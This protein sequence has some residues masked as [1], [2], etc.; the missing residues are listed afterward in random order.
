MSAAAPPLP[1]A[2]R[3]HRLRRVDWRFLLPS[4]LP[5]RTLCLAT[6][7]LAEG[8]ALVS[9]EVVSAAAPGTCDLALAQD[10][11]DRTLETLHAALRPGGACYTEWR[12]PRMRGV[13]RA[14][15]ALAHA[16]FEQIAGYWP[17]P[18]AS[19]V[20]PRYWIPL[21][22]PGAAA[23]VRSRDRAE[24]GRLRQVVAAS[25]H[26]ARDAA[27]TLRCARPV[28][29]IALRPPVGTDAPVPWLR[30][31]WPGWGVG[32]APANPS[33]LLLTGG[34]RSVSKVVTLVF[35]EPD[36]HPRLAIKAPRVRES[37][38]PVEREATVLAT[39]GRRAPSALPPGVPRLLFTRAVDGLPLVGETALVGRPLETLLSAQNFRSWAT[40]GADWLTGLVG[41][42]PP[43]PTAHWWPTTVQPVLSDFA[44][45]FGPVVDPDTLQAAEAVLREIDGLPAACEQRDFGPWNLLVSPDGELAVLDWESAVTDG[46]P[47]LDLLY[48]LA[49]LTFNVDHAEG[50]E[51]RVASYRR[52]LDPATPA[53]AVRRDCLARY[54]ERL[55]LPSS[56][57]RPLRVLVWLVH[58]R[59]EFHHFAAD[60]GGRPGASA[61]RRS[62][63]LALWHEEMR[64]VSEG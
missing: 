3:N 31:G 25:T 57:L 30:T 21:D 55:G 47:V 46:L 18:L 35:D 2:E 16:G 28:C 9:G 50:L 41:G 14:A 19:A 24:G 56:Q 44:E 33:R 1:E 4:P 22:A 36:P 5:G 63:F 59:S 38:G 42:D 43:Q 64:H 37:F 20:G 52:A 8:A 60:A 53:G 10:P 45:A 11:D 58:A 48:F 34:P 40:Q 7:P 61:L 49:H 51:A 39:I 12:R 32:P 62:L 17:W 27:L 23:F 26:A 29:V 15:A 13:D 54:C 6:G